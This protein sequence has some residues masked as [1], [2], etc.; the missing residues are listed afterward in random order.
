M[1]QQDIAQYGVMHAARAA[2]PIVACLGKQSE[3][4]AP[5]GWVILPAEQSVAF[6]AGDQ[7]GQSARAEHHASG[8]VGHAELVIGCVEQR[9]QDVELLSFPSVGKYSSEWS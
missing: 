6:H 4:L 9:D 8:K 3:E 2:Q 5:V 1:P 7:V